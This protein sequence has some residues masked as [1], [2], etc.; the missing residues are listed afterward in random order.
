MNR[1]RKQ[2]T[3]DCRVCGRPFQWRKK[4]Q[5]NWHNVRHCS[6]RCSR[7]SIGQA[8]RV[9]EQ[10]ILECLNQANGTIAGVALFKWI[11]DRG[12]SIGQERVKSA[13]RRLANQGKLV[14]MKEGQRIDAHS[15]RGSFELK[16]CAPKLSHG[17]KLGF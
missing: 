14:W 15:C 5:R 8:D 6:N 16:R 17:D 1:E 11:R 9:A 13:A 4:W 7:Q 3:K 12:R 2:A 10:L